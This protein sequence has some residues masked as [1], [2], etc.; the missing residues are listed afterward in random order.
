MT[1]E[2][3]AGA[4]VSTIAQPSTKPAD[5]R[6]SS[7]PTKKRPNWNAANLETDSLGRSHRSKTVSYTHLDV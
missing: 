5:P 1:N 3:N 6:F 4:G 2:N 7:G